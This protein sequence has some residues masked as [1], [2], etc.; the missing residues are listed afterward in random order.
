MWAQTRR[1]SIVL[2]ALLVAGG[3]TATKY[4]AP[5]TEVA[6]LPQ[7]C[8]AQYMANV[9][10]PEYSIEDCGPFTNHYCDGLLELARAQKTFGNKSLRIHH[11]DIA[12]ENT[13][14]TLKGISAYPSC[15]IR[16]HAEATLIRVNDLLRASGA[17]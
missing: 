14:Y 5:A 3:A 7:F 9:E 10:G 16:S 13:L 8:W 2:A 4:N 17:K 15:A 6:L 11:L 12:K 1:V